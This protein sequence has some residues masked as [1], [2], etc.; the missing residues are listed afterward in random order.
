MYIPPAKSWDDVI[1]FIGTDTTLDKLKSYLE[2]K[3][4]ELKFPENNTGNWQGHAVARAACVHNIELIKNII[5]IAGKHLLGPVEGMTPLISCMF[6]PNE[7]KLLQ[8]IEVLLD[9]GSDVNSYSPRYGSP[10]HLAVEFGRD[11]TIISFLVSRGAV[12]TPP[13][14]K[15]S[16]YE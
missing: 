12:S 3:H 16:G 14:I 10:L 11:Q 5:S 6:S 13:V 7:G 15:R 4:P 2:T 1:R 9:L 8:T